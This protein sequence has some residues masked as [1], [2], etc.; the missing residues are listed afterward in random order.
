MAPC[1][2]QK[3]SDEPLPNNIQ[4]LHY[5]RYATERTIL[6]IAD[7]GGLD[8]QPRDDYCPL[9]YGTGTG[10]GDSVSMRER[11]SNS[12]GDGFEY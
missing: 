10:M 11:V 1:C 5:H 8:W 6:E 9:R 2:G 4:G 7:S 12:T 3:R